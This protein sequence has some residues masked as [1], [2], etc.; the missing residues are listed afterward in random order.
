MKR[1]VLIFLILGIIGARAETSGNATPAAQC[2]S[3]YISEIN[4]VSVADTDAGNVQTYVGFGQSKEEAEKNALGACSHFRFDLQTC[5]DSDRSSGRN[6]DSNDSLHLKY[7]K[8]VKRITG[9]G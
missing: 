7:M 8:A 5:L 9:C 2:S 3:Y 4:I 1:A 6:A